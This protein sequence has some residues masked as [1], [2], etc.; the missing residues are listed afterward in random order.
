MVVTLHIF[1][2]STQ[3]FHIELIGSDFFPLSFNIVLT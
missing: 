2:L 1:A 3:L